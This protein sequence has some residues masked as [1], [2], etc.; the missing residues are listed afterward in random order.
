MLKKLNKYIQQKIQTNYNKSVDDYIEL[1]ERYTD[2]L[3]E[4]IFT[5]LKTN[6]HKVN[7]YRCKSY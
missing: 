3:S 6:I 5:N 4:Y 1:M 2:T 7:L